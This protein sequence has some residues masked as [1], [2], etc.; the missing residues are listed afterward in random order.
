MPRGD[1]PSS[2]RAFAPGS[3]GNIGPG[4]DILGCA[5]TGAGDAVRATRSDYA[6]VQ[7]DEPGHA[8]LSRDPI[9]HA[10]AIAAREV[11][12]RAGRET[13]GVSLSV[14]KGL[15]LSGGQGGSAAS[16]IAGA[17]ATNALFGDPLSSDELLLAALSAE[18]QVAGRHLDNL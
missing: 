4:L 11:L 7:V 8:E 12:R 9:R 2:I 3:I 5:L 16:A 17:L 14:E 13:T 6:G 1:P 18:E 10:S 15:P